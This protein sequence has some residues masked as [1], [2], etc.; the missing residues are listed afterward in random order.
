MLT[1]IKGMTAPP[2]I[3]HS[4]L[5]AMM[6]QSFLVAYRYS[7]LKLTFTS[8]IS[9]CLLIISFS[10]GGRCGYASSPFLF[11]GILTIWE[12]I[13]FNW[14]MSSEDDPEECGPCSCFSSTNIF[15]T[16][17][18]SCDS[19]LSCF[20]ILA[21]TSL[22]AWL[23]SPAVLSMMDDLGEAPSRSKYFGEASNS[24]MMGTFER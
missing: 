21:P 17:E 9:N 18:S 23:R 13:S 22:A 4:E 11:S 16:E 19:R 3:A 24:R 12:S 7:V 14:A 20:S 15:A 6:I 5:I 1:V 8:G 10:C 2:A